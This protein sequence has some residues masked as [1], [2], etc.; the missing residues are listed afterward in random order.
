MSG[1]GGDSF[2]AIVA[3]TNT[4]HTPMGPCMYDYAEVAV[5]RSGSAMLFGEF[6]HRHLRVGDVT[7]LAPCTLYGWEPEGWV[8]ITTLY[9]DRDFLTDQVFW[10]YAAT[11]TDRFDA[12]HFI[13]TRFTDPAQV[14]RLGEDRAGLLMP[15]LDELVTLSIDGPPP[16]RFYRA[17]SLLFSVFDVLAPHLVV[18]DAAGARRRSRARPTVPRH[19]PVAPVR[20]EARHAAELLRGSLHEQWTLTRLAQTVHLSPSQIGRVF[21]DAFGKT[22][23]AYLTML[24]AERMAHLLRTTD[25]PI[26]T[27]ARAVGWAD[28]DYAGRLFRRSIGFAPRQYRKLSRQ[29]PAAGGTGG[30]P[31]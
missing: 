2:S 23:I 9:L 1:T 12:Q 8:T 18:T 21:A 16:E 28:P 4:A 13:E 26:A 3:R 24:R 22:P 15:W 17:Q 27:A 5:V 30:F 7:L 6:G 31:R 20:D 29:V 10:Q 19:R 14:V 25:D 11:F